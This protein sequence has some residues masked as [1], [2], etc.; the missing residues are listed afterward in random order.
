MKKLSAIILAAVLLFT[1]AAC[2][3]NGGNE[4]TTEATT[5]AAE[6]TTEATTEATTEPET[7]APQEKDL[8]LGTS[9]T[10]NDCEITVNKISMSKKCKVSL[11]SNVSTSREAGE[12]NVFII[13]DCDVKNVGTSEADM[14][15]SEDIFKVS[16]LYDGKYSYEQERSMVGE[17][18]IAPLSEMQEC[19]LIEVPAVVADGT[20][21]LELTFTFE[22]ETY[23]H[24][25]R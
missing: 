9:Y 24:T 19:V 8:A 12:G 4:K 15:S 5:T 10:S 17:D 18:N 13:I 2:G 14:Y 22:G 6:T 23:K 11:G 25:V 20:E 1:L 16:A 3:G 7:T 21:P